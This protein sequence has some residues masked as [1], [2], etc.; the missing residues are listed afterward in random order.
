[1]L[2]MAVE[3]KTKNSVLQPKP[4]I[5]KLARLWSEFYGDLAPV[6]QQ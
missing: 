6:I 5:Q 2:D 4:G 1:M 3:V